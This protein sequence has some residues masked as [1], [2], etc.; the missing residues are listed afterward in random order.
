MAGMKNDRKIRAGRLET[1]DLLR[2]LT[3]ISMILYHG[4]WD[5]IYLTGTG[6]GMEGLR[7]W[8][9]GTGGHL[10]QQSI[11]RTFI[12]LSGF[13]VPFS[14]RIFRRGLQVSGGGLVVTAVTLLLM[15]EER[16]VFGVLTF[17]GAAMLLS[18]AVDRLAQRDAEGWDY[19]EAG[20]RKDRFV[21]RDAEGW[22]CREAGSRKDRPDPAEH[23]P[24]ARGTGRALAGLLFCLVLFYITRWV[25]IGFLRPGP[26][27]QIPLPSFLYVS[28]ELQENVVGRTAGWILT[29]LG[30]PMKGFFS[31][32]YFSLFPWIFLFRAG[33]WMH[34]ALADWK[35]NLF[36]HPVFYAQVPVLN[37]MGRHSL[38]VYLLHQP[39]LYLL[40]S[41]LS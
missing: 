30:F 22:D 37:W 12:L 41:L 21:Q 32:D 17:L 40:I 24:D 35:T 25:N 13:C 19:R 31:T 1:L 9:E 28:A 2:G 27:L 11:C 29:A 38:L 6:A 34:R 10:W 5:F 26:R 20:G 7:T 15:Y 14:R 4:M 33:T 23:T 16:V 8:Y 3:L 18:G 36:R 39:V